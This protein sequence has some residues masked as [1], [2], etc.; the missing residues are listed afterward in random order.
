MPGTRDIALWKFATKDVNRLE[1]REY[2]QGEEGEDADISFM[3]QVR[4]ILPLPVKK[5]VPAHKGGGLDRATDEKLRRGQMKIVGRIDLHGL[6]QVEAQ[7]ELT[8]F[9]L[10]SYERGRRCVL[11]ITGKG[12]RHG[13]TGGVLKRKG[14]ESLGL[15]PLKDLVLQSH[16]AKPQHGG[17]GALYVLLRRNKN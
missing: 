5:P 4:E 2:A 9:I 13:E 8:D 15:S 11:V 17:A 14:P 16:P 7:E 3:E 1:G 10:R 6:T 12:A